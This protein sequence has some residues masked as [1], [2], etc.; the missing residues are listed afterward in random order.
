MIKSVTVLL[1]S[2]QAITVSNLQFPDELEFV[3]FL[4]CELTASK[5]VTIAICSDTG[6]HNMFDLIQSL[7]PTHFICNGY[8]CLSA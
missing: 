2:L 6:S 7:V 1:Q 8:F 4:F 5:L 3:H